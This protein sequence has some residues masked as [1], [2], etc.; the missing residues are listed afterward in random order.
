[1]TEFLKD[2]QFIS[3][4]YDYGDKQLK[5]KDS[6]IIVSK[7]KD[8]NKHIQQIK[9]PEFSFYVTKDDYDMKGKNFLNFIDF[10][11]ANKITCK[12]KN[13]YSEMAK[14]T[15]NREIKK[16]YKQCVD[17][18]DYRRLKELNYF[19]EF[20]GTDVS[21][22]DYY[23][24]SFL[25]QN[26][27]QKNNYDIS[28]MS[29]DIEVDGSDYVGFPNEEIAPCPV[30]MITAYNN[31]NKKLYVFALKYDTDTFSDF[32][33]VEKEVYKYVLKKYRYILGKYT[34][35]PR[36]YDNELALIANFF[37]QVNKDK[38][39]Y[40]LAWNLRFDFLTLY[41]RLKKLCAG[42]DI[43][44]ED[45]M[46]PEEFPIHKVSYKL[47]NSANDI[48]DRVDVFQITGFSNWMD[49]ECLYANIT[50]PNGKKESYSLD[51][52]GELETGMHKEEIEDIKT[53]HLKDYS[54]F[55]KY[56]SVD[57]LLLAS[58]L[59]ETTHVELLHT[60][61]TMTRTRPTKALKKT[62]SLRNFA[63]YFYREN[64]KTISNNHYY[65]D[66]ESGR[67]KGAFVAPLKN[68]GKVGL[69][70]GIPSNKLFKYVIDFDLSSLYPSIT[71]AFNIS[72]DTLRYKISI[73]YN[74]QIPKYIENHDGEKIITSMFVE[75]FISGD[76]I[77]YCKTYHNYPDVEEM[78]E[79]IKEKLLVH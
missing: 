45:I 69:I 49:A 54:S 48:C 27:Y 77:N 63:D 10:N 20:H 24:A 40:V 34:I 6:I 26:D 11:D 38:P 30:N 56:S 5:E 19:P 42:T 41:N 2:E 44:P 64:N 50:K 36:F 68:I 3:C 29:F 17:Y 79:L 65:V 60:I 55:F 15:N 31:Q 53:I 67:I 35:V 46:C 21:I 76:I 74:E 23:I 71:R 37:N 61:V 78:M 7:D 72:K 1:M 13:R 28:I 16:F 58:I 33:K 70:N 39:D 9:Q 18:K 14:C 22:E 73:V 12:Y 8:G 51:Y 25:D 32:K 75:E 57:S 66:G 43:F 4:I 47:D 62:V 59:T 52:I